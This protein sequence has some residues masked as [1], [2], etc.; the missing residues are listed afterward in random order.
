MLGVAWVIQ[1]DATEEYDQSVKERGSEHDGL[2][3]MMILKEATMV[4]HKMFCGD[5][6]KYDSVG[7]HEGLRKMKKVVV[8]H[9]TID[10]S[11]HLK[12]LQMQ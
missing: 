4:L 3:E 10:V 9:K 11:K 1:D 2:K 7:G 5:S 12:W 6:V 8:I